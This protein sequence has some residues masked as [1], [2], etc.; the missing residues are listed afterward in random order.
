LQ[1]IT[2]NNPH[3]SN[4]LINE[5]SEFDNNDNSNNN[6]PPI[7]P[8]DKR[9]VKVLHGEKTTSEMNKIV[10]YLKQISYDGYFERD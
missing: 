6:A 7:I 10:Y 1:E 8:D 4:P 2:N 9:D 3:I 5:E